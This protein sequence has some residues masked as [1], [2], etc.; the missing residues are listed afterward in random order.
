MYAKVKTGKHLS[1]EF[2]VNEGL[3]KEDAIAPLLFM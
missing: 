1:S 3:T 2:Q